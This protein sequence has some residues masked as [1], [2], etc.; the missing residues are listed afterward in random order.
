M[1]IVGFLLACL[2][3]AIPVIAVV[4]LVRSGKVRQLI[5]ET[6]TELRGELS[7]LR[8]EVANLRR[9][10]SRLSGSVSQQVPSASVHSTEAL[11]EVPPI[12]AAAT[13][14][15][16][17]KP[18]AADPSARTIPPAPPLLVQAP[19]IAPPPVVVKPASLSPGQLSEAPAWASHSAASPMPRLASAHQFREQSRNDSVQAVSTANPPDA[20][21]SCKEAN[22]PYLFE[23]A[24]PSFTSGP[25]R[26]TFADHLRSTLPFEEL[27]G[28]NLFAKIGIILLVLG[29]ALL[30][31]MALIAMGPGQ[32]VSLIYA[33]SAAM[34][35]GGVWLET[36]ER[37]R[38]IGRAGIGGGWALFF[39]TTY[40]MHHVSAMAVLASNTL[41][42]V[43]MLLVAVSMVAHTIRYKSQVVTG[44]A[45]LL[46]FSTVALSQDSV[47]ALVAGV[48]LAVGHHYQHLLLFVSLF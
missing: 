30:G 7:D 25:P 14:A 12:I 38:L 40:A 34:L 35:G 37:Y 42:C 16:T 41:D 43:L 13:E 20:A 2:V 9:D 32:R 46:A 6:N 19:P 17:T 3:L 28:M 45:F 22:A 33:A 21:Q 36:R 23:A 18:I 15:A 44:L 48:I 8:S 10:V 5:E 27:L 26:K 24:T 4:A 1:E 47:Y 11:T 31:R 39:F 29:F